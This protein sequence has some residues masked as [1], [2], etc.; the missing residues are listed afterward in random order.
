VALPARLRSR[1]GYVS[2]L[3]RF[4]GFYGPL[5]ER[6]A[7]VAGLDALGLDLRD[8]RKAPLLRADL[9]SLGMTSHALADLPVC[10]R[11]PSLPSLS[12]ALGCLYVLEGATLG[13]QIVRREV[14]RT[15]GFTPDAGCSFFASYRERVGAMWNEFCEAVSL[16]TARNPEAEGPLVEAAMETFAGMDDWLAGGNSWEG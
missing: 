7:V 10:D 6:L 14:Q 1:D 11:V 9:V 2:L 16:H 3:A 5:E 8:R 12:E 13:G 4:H 15:Y